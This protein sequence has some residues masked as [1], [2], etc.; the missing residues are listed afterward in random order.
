MKLEL[1]QRMFSFLDSYDVRDEYG[2]AVFTVKS[3]LAFGHYFEVYDSENICRALVRQKLFSWR[4][5]FDIYID[6]EYTGCISKNFSFFRPSYTIDFMDWK[7]E[8]EL[9][10]LRYNYRICDRYGNTHA[11][12]EKKLFTFSDTYTVDIAQPEEALPVVLLV[13]SIDAV[14]CSDNEND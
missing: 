1:K 4:H 2:C 9:D 11:Y 10:F 5:K 6:N 3:R 8:G 12:I 7:A 14:A 13:L